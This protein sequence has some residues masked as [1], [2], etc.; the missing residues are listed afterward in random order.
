VSASGA[1]QSI[2]EELA[3]AALRHAATLPRWEDAAEAFAAAVTE[4]TR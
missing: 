3:R 2:R 1:S 4:L